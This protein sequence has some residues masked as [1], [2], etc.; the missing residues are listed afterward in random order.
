MMRKLV[1]LVCLPLI[2]VMPAQAQQKLYPVRGTVAVEKTPY[3]EDHFDFV[4]EKT[5]EYKL[6]LGFPTNDQARFIRDT[7]ASVV[8]LWLRVENLS[9]QPLHIDSDKFTAKGPDGR[10]YSRLNGDE[11]F[12]RIIEGKG[13]TGK[14][15]T[16]GLRSVTLGKAASK[17][18]EEDARDEAVRFSFQSGDVPALGVKQGLIYF[19][20]P[21]DKTFTVNINLGDLSERP[22]AFT[23]IKPKR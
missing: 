9:K 20:G 4:I 16:K 18:S 14:A 2:A 6:T 1:L 3:E 22:F 12:S 5:F 8:V 17:S 19:E 21:A 7:N 23:N 10:P 11:A 15:L 13:L